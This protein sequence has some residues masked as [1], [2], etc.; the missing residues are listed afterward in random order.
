MNRL[1]R[2]IAIG[3]ICFSISLYAKEKAEEIVSI[4]K[5]YLSEILKQKI[6]LDARKKKLKAKA[7]FNTIPV[8]YPIE[9]THTLIASSAPRH[10][11]IFEDGSTWKIKSSDMHKL[12]RWKTGAPRKN[13]T[14]QELHERAIGGYYDKDE[15]PDILMFT[16]NTSWLSDYP[17]II[18]NCTRKECVE[19]GLILGGGPILDGKYTN[20]IDKLDFDESKVYLKNIERNSIWDLCESD[21]TTYRSWAVEDCIIIGFNSGS[22][23]KYPYILYNANL[24]NWVRVK[25]HVK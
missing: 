25:P 7:L 11:M 17:I 22:G 16:Q 20:T 14:I 15:N 1:N 5:E 6:P 3:I 21:F 9:Y 24:Q 2:T 8:R 18:V 13:L 12:I 19:A 23:Y 4:D 10:T